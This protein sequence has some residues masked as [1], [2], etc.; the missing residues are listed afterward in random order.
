MDLNAIEKFKSSYLN[1]IQG[2][3]KKDLPQALK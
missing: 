2:I 1:V 3:K